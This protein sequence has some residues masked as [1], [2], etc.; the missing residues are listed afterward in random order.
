MQTTKKTTSSA[1][2]YLATF[3]GDLDAA[4]AALRAVSKPKALPKKPPASG[5]VLI[6]I[7]NLTK[8]YKVGSQRISALKG[9]SLEIRQGEFVA[10]TG[11]S[12]SGKSTLLQLIGGLDKPS[13]GTITVDGHDL[14]A[15]SDRKLSTF[16]NKTVGFVFQFYHLLPELTML[17]NTLAPLMIGASTWTYWRKRKE[18]TDRAK[19]LLEVSCLAVNVD[20]TRRGNVDAEVAL[21]TP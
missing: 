6:D 15:L 20:P 13:S 9:V 16:R 1:E 2:Q 5:Q 18:Y 17:E 12:G 3:N 4:M 8:D 21:R 10:F 19:L 7:E 14:M 11:A